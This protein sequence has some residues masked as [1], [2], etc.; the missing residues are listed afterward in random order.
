MSRNDYDGKH[1]SSQIKLKEYVQGMFDEIHSKTNIVTEENEYYVKLCD[2]VK[3]HP[4]Y[5]TRYSNRKI[6]SYLFK[7]GWSATSKNVYHMTLNFENG[8]EVRMQ[9]EYSQS[10][11]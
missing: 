3:R 2:L 1:F 4:D 6:K 9:Y 8:E 11:K 7:L 5:M 10:N